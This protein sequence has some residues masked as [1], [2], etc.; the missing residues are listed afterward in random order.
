MKLP[1]LSSSITEEAQKDERNKPPVDAVLR[2]P[3]W[4]LIYL[5][6]AQANK[7]CSLSSPGS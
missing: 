7:K 6:C 3:F 5:H 1:C 2:T 4:T